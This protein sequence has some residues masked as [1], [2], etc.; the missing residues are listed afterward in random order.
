M[1]Q[2][3]HWMSSREPQGKEVWAEKQLS[4]KHVSLRAATSIGG[5]RS[6]YTDNQ[7]VV[8]VCT[9]E[10][11]LRAVVVDGA[12]STTTGRLAATICAET[13]KDLSFSLEQAYLQADTQICLQTRTDKAFDPK[14][15]GYGAVVG[16]DVDF[17]TGTAQ[18]V[19]WGDC[20]AVLLRS[21]AVN[22]EGATVPQNVL[23]D[24]VV[25]GELTLE[26]Y[27]ASE[28]PS[29]LSGGLGFSDLPGIRPPVVQSCV[30]QVGDVIVL[31]SDGV[32][33]QLSDYELLQLWLQSGKDLNAFDQAVRALVFE[34]NNATRPF[35]LKIE[36]GRST[37]FCPDA[38]DNVSLIVLQWT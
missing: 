23:H 5:P 12:G 37:H 35:E 32:W 8:L 16:I 38:A 1:N 26:A 13:A 15:S 7:D 2:S 28:E 33:D 31:G 14:T 9:D 3:T 29:Y 27:F 34:R 18:I 25:A 20:R 17:Q 22:G 24:R 21:N 10:K 19:Y 36:A 6:R 11:R 30:L 4:L